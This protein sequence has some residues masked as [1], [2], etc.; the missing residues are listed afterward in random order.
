MR[1]VLALLGVLPGAAPQNLAG[2][3][4]VFKQPRAR[5]VTNAL[6]YEPTLRTG[7]SYVSFARDY[8]I[9]PT[10]STTPST[11]SF[12]QGYYGH[13]LLPRLHACGL[14]LV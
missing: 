7:T 2:Y 10:P 4:C 9:P 13:K 5:P 11:C 8:L 3:T 14:L 6:L 1:L 12:L